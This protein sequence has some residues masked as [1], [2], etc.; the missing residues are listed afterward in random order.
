MTN[1]VKKYA[2]AAYCG[3]SNAV[4]KKNAR[5]ELRRTNKQLLRSGKELR[6]RREESNVYDS[7]LDGTVH[8]CKDGPLKVNQTRPR[9]KRIKLILRSEWWP[10]KIFRK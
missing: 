7:P 5:K 10:N 2:F 4:W 6:L 1:S 9:G 8:F 3:G